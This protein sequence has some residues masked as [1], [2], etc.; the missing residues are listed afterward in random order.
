MVPAQA[1]AAGLVAVPVSG[2]ARLDPGLRA[3]VVWVP[4][5]RGGLPDGDVIIATA[6]QSAA[7]VADAPA[8][9]GR[10]FYFVQHYESLYHGQA[11]AVD[12]TYRLPLRKIVISTW[13]PDVMRG[14]L[15][16]RRG[17]YGHPVDPALFHPVPGHGIGRRASL[18]LHHDYPWKGTADGFETV[19]RV[20]AQ[21]P[22]LHL[23]GFGVSRRRGAAVRRVSRRSAT[24]RLAALYSR[25][26]DLSLPVLGRGARHAADGGDGLRRRALHV[27][28]WRLPGLRERRPHGAGGAAPRR[29]RPGPGAGATGRGRSPSGPHRRRWPGLRHDAV[30]LGRATARFEALLLAGR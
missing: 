21:Y 29:R 24:R 10:K 2:G 17:G 5:A 1:D 18:M 25:L 12:A 30:R 8:R 19:A 22:G 15:R 20:K 27:R 23:I 7:A 4:V 9:C 14:A 13:L 11:D 6:W 26:P 3:R 16:Q 28:Q